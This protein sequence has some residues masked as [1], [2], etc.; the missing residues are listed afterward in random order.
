MSSSIRAVFT[1]GVV[2]L[3]GSALVVC[4][5][6][7]PARV[8]VARPVTIAASVTA[9]TSPVEPPSA[10]ELKSALT[11][12]GHL[13][14]PPIDADGTRVEVAAL[15]DPAVLNAASTVIDDVYAVTRYW[16]NYVSLELGPW[17]L[18][19][20]PLGYLISDQIYIWYPDFVLPTVDS[21]VYDFLDPVVNDVLNP[22]VWLDGI[23]A[24]INTAANGVVNGI[25][26]EI[27]YVL[28]L[29]WFPIPLPPLPTP[30]LPRVAV[31]S[32][33]AVTAA[34]SS[35]VDEV[36]TDTTDEP[37]ALR[38]QPVTLEPATSEVP[39]ETG[40]VADTQPVKEA[41]PAADDLDETGSDEAA[42]EE[43]AV[44]EGAAEE[45]T[46]EEGTEELDEEEPLTAIDDIAPAD[47]SADGQKSETD[48]PEQ[49]SAG[50]GQTPSADHGDDGDAKTD[51]GNEAGATE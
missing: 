22:A 16:A 50:S 18:N 32:T 33:P 38:G 11:L 46:A 25:A 10:D 39:D 51:A 17:L 42:V 5:S 31:E 26:A 40:V 35:E 20:L 43:A 47:D 2:A 21:F 7:L 49:E 14:Q 45:G 48:D 13:A 1:A 19:W 30:P 34:V 23:N 24:V 37:L 36:L 6:L 4:P 9:L 15:D 27:N 41:E 3:T 8:E 44:E 28:S 12:V 29:G